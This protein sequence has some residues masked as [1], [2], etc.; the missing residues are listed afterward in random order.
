MPRPHAAPAGGRPVRRRTAIGG[1]GVVVAAG[2]AAFVLLGGD[3]GGSAGAASVDD[4]GTTTATVRRTDLVERDTVSGALGYADP[5]TVVNRLRGTYTRLPEPGT[6]LR[7]G[8]VLY[9]VDGK[10]GAILLDGSLPAWRDLRVGVDDGADVEELERN[11]V[12]LGYDPNGDVTVDEHFDWATK[13]AV[14]RLQDAL[15]L[16]QTGVLELGRAVFQET[17]RRVATVRAQLGGSAGPGPV[18]ETTGTGRTVTVALDAAKQD[19]AVA[20][21]AVQVELPDSSVVEAR[22]SSVGRV[23]RTTENGTVVDLTVTLKK[24]A[25]VPALDQ[26]PVSVYLVRERRRD[27]LAVPV[28]ALVARP[29]GGYAVES[30]DDHRLLPVSP[31]LY[32]DSLVEVSG[33]SV[34]AGLRV[35]VP[36]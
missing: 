8:S 21:E 24:G 27:V 29:G 33:P 13:A 9:D 6:V 26:A 28:T 22:V 35:A 30:A 36:A 18:Y 15:G 10:P 14:E 3:S 12:A 4:S 2:I 1:A 7:G 32:A 31:G 20:G 16:E 19:E 34:H 5:Q 17:P 23:A 11:L 25:A